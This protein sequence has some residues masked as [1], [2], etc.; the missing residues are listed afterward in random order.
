MKI[1][2]LVIRWW[3]GVL[4]ATAKN[5][6][7][8]DVKIFIIL[9]VTWY[10][11]KYTSYFPFSLSIMSFIDDRDSPPVPFSLISA[12]YNFSLRLSDKQGLGLGSTPLF[13]NSRWYYFKMNIIHLSWNLN[14]TRQFY[15]TVNVA[16]STS[17]TT[18]YRCEN[19]WY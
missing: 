18:Y 9:A 2:R 3:I 6:K 5:G 17:P 11:T 4:Q 10:Q 8:A 1:N 13:N 12:N 14:S 16:S 19:V 7:C 15:F